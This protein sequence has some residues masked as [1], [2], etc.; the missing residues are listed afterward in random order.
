MHLDD[1]ITAD[2][3]GADT[4]NVWPNVDAERLAPING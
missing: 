3:A 4:T 2:I 1:F